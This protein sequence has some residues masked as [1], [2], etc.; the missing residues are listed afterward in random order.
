MKYLFAIILI[1]FTSM[2]YAQKEADKDHAV[3]NTKHG[4]IIIEFFDKIAPMHVESF[5]I[6]AN[7]NYF[8]GTTFHRVIP[9]FV[10]QGGDP[11]S[12]LEDRTKHG[13]GG[14][15]GKYYGV[16]EEENPETWTIPAEFSD[17]PHNRG[18]VSMARTPDPNSASS[19]FFIC[20]DNVNRL[21]NQYTVFGQVIKGMKVVD[22]IVNLPRD[23]RDNPLESVPMT[24]QI[25]SKKSKK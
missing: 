2:I 6:L 7:E 13:T 9:N 8:N 5:K 19:Q 16:G 24:V 18:A 3:I 20:V 1:G 17:M 14:R 21:D 23:E 25:I 12:R 15:A 10:I 11:N 4:E 22:K